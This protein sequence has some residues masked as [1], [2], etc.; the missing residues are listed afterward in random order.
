M[1][2]RKLNPDLKTI[3]IFQKIQNFF[4]EQKCFQSVSINVHPACI[5]QRLVET[6]II[7]VEYHELIAHQDIDQNFHQVTVPVDFFHQFANSLDI[8]HFISNI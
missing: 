1:A 4:G 3:K 8:F 2:Q 5:R 7:Y 6:I